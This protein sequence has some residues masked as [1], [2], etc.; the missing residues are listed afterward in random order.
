MNWQ[1]GS[2]AKRIN[3]I[4]QS[5]NSKRCRIEADESLYL[6]PQLSLNRPGFQHTME[7]S[8][9]CKIHKQLQLSSSLA[10][11]GLLNG[12]ISTLDITKSPSHRTQS[13]VIENTI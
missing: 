4:S 8:H 12:L 11:L 10:F 1:F 5:L 3:Q 2:N 6:D 9:D 7:F 13:T